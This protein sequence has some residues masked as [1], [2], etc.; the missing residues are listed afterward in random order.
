MKS[1]PK[2][3]MRMAAKYQEKGNNSYADE[4]SEGA[5]RIDIPGKSI[6]D[7]KES[8]PPSPSDEKDK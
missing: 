3:D 2:G 4:L 5:K 1:Q 7:N 6:V 8:P